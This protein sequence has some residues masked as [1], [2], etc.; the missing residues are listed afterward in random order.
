MV[1]LYETQGPSG[2]S[3]SV[4]LPMV[5]VDISNNNTVLIFTHIHL[6][7]TTSQRSL[8]ICLSAYIYMSL[9]VSELDVIYIS[10]HRSIDRS[11]H[12]YIYIS[13]HIYT[14]LSIFL[15]IYPPCIKISIYLCKELS[16]YANKFICM[17]S[18]TN[19]SIPEAICPLQSSNLYNQPS[20]SIRQGCQ[21]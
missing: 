17:S 11:I 7:H 4:E 18:C 10:I 12:L 19:T 15:T 21:D 8:T 6:T 5:S 2:L 9:Y 14:Y 3:S 20:Q 1:N 13:I 16:I